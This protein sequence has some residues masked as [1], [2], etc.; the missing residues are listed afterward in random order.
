MS[1]TRPIDEILR[2]PANKLTEEER[3]KL[4][5]YSNRRSGRRAEGVGSAVVS[6]IAR[7]SGKK[8]EKPVALRP[9]PASEPILPVHH[10][11][12]KLFGKDAQVM[13]RAFLQKNINIEEHYINVMAR[14]GARPTVAQLTE[15]IEFEASEEL[16][17]KVRIYKPIL[18]YI[19]NEMFKEIESFKLEEA[20]QRKVAKESRKRPGWQKSYRDN[21]NILK[22][23]YR[24]FA[25]YTILKAVDDQYNTDCKGF[26]DDDASLKILARKLDC[27]LNTVKSRRDL[28]FKYK[29]AYRN[30]DNHWQLHSVSKAGDGIGCP[31]ADV[32]YTYRRISSNLKDFEDALKLIWEKKIKS[33]SMTEM[34]NLRISE[35]EVRKELSD[36]CGVHPLALNREVL[37]N[38]QI[39][40][41]HVQDSPQR[42][43]VE[44]LF[45]FNTNEDPGYR[46]LSMFNGYT[47]RG[48]MAYL[49]R[50]WI[51]KGQAL[52]THRV[53]TDPGYKERGA[54]KTTHV[55]PRLTPFYTDKLGIRR[56]RKAQGGPCLPLNSAAKGYWH[57]GVKATMARFT[58]KIESLV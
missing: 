46:K 2:L 6:Y 57:P 51:K 13:R 32:N 30:G 18:V 49:K 14:V 4:I 1:A 31:G 8:E 40:A 35:H 15:G 10:A 39:A 29:M 27:S 47:S 3:L 25:F 58:D 55:R 37:L 20:N 16:N 53:I 34:L 12:N 28:L 43:Y 44:V 38:A 42:P 17:L 23:K 33:F 56:R 54:R 36:I 5:A 19:H 7:S 45:M 52:I 9:P 48:G 22:E 26:D 24:A 41:F 21:Q 11:I 50:K